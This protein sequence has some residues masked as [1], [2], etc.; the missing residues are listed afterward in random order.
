ML[1]W[2]AFPGQ[3][4]DSAGGM[5]PVTGGPGGK[6]A[7]DS[8]VTAPVRANALPFSAAPVP[9]ETDACARMVPT[10]IELALS[11]A[12]LPTCQKT[13]AACAPP[14][15]TTWLLTSAKSVLAIWKTQTP[16]AG[17]LRVRVSPTPILS[18]DVDT[19][20][21]GDSVCPPRSPTFV[22]VGPPLR[23]G[24]AASLYAIVRSL[25]AVAAAPLAMSYTPVI[26]PGGNPVRAVPGFSP[27]LPFTVVGPL[28]V[29]VEAPKT[30]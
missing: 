13:L 17:P 14:V 7:L 5:P 18:D 9:R 26:L 21:P 23:F 2:A 6:I 16:F 30:P 1:I 3:A 20:R 29:T 8:K 28:L 12:E 22:M 27:R 11:V 19:Y 15:R 10:K 24:V 25:W 4:T